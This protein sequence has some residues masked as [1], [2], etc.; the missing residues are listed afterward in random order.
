MSYLPLKF[1][2]SN[3]FP[4][5]RISVRPD[6]HIMLSTGILE[7][8]ICRKAESTACTGQAFL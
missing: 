1:E 8:N 4:K 3:I 2:N 5:E 7:N 6:L